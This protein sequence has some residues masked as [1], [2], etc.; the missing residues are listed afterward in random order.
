MRFWQNVTKI[1]F[2]NEVNYGVII[3]IHSLN[4]FSKVFILNY[5]TC[6]LYSFEMQRK[7]LVM[8]QQLHQG[9]K[10]S[11]MSIICE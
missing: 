6:S 5:S 11:S 1:Q 2:E 4:F 10:W 3:K 7:D 9:E 8:E